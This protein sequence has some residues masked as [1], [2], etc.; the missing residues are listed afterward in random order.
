MSDAQHN[1]T[2][3]RNPRH[4]KRGPERQAMIERLMKSNTDFGAT[5]AVLRE[6]G[7][8]KISEAAYAKAR[9]ELRV[10]GKAQRQ[11]KR[12]VEIALPQQAEPTTFVLSQK[13]FQSVADAA[14]PH[15]DTLAAMLAQSGLQQITI[16]SDGDMKVDFSGSEYYRRQ[17]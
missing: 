1:S 7:F 11:T 12:D 4:G 9:K 16:N 13:R 6:H 15:A 2:E 5:N 14:R 10:S 3:N 8:V 17:S